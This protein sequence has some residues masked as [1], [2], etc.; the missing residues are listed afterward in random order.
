MYR[1]VVAWARSW[2][3][4][5][6]AALVAVSACE[7]S[8]TATPE[9][10]AGQSTTSTSDPS[11]TTSGPS[12][13]SGPM[14][15]RG[16]VVRR[17]TAGGDGTLAWQDP[18]DDAVGFVDVERVRFSPQGQPHWYI[19]LA[20]E[21]PVPADREPGQLIAYGLVLDTTGDGVAD[22]VVGIDNDA[23]EQ[24]DFHVWVTDLATGE[25]A[26]QIGPP[27]GVPVEFSHPDEESGPVEPPTMVFTFLAGTRPAGLDSATVRFY[28]W[29]S[30]TR[31]GTLV[32]SDY[33]PDSGWVSGGTG[34]VD[35]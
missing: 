35:G 26:E 7:S 15:D 30:T 23:P 11:T 2:G 24:G 3:L 34:H 19:E 27:Y 9:T 13:W 29:T 20:A 14:L 12:V 18:L 22:H 1:F 8:D 28:A 5:L 33:A 6:A 32:A 21:P 31:D 4:M 25:T 17:M 16:T 10:D